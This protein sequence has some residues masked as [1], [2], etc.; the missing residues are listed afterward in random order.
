M[1]AL[2]KP[3]PFGDTGHVSLFTQATSPEFVQVW[4]LFRSVNMDKESRVL[5]VREGVSEEK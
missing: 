1:E 2:F 4:E 3:V 5:E